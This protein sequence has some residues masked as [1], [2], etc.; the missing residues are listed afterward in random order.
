MPRTARAS[1]GNWCY[2]ILNRGNARAEVF[3]KDED[4][5][6]FFGSLSRHASGCGCGFSATA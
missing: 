4:Y 5:A 6:A 3:H 2:H 1:L